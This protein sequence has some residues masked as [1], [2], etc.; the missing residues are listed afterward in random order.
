MYLKDYSRRV[1]TWTHIF[2]IVLCKA[3]FSPF[4]RRRSS[5]WSEILSTS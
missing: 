5:N 1:S 3:F 2:S 4:K